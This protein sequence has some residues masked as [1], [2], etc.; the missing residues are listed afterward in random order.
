MSYIVD[1]F[2]MKVL[3]VAYDR[4]REVYYE[5]KHT[6]L[7]NMVFFDE[8][9]MESV[10]ALLRKLEINEV[11]CNDAYTM[12]PQKT[13]IFRSKT[14]LKRSAV[15]ENICSQCNNITCEHRKNANRAPKNEDIQSQ[16]LNY[17][18]QRIL[19]NRGNDLW[20]KD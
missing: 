2:A 16:K 3:R 10:P 15:C 19:G 20:K 1:A 18:Y 17:G 11:R 4:Y 5:K 12:I 7:E 14:T 9:E 8:K 13:V 6:Y